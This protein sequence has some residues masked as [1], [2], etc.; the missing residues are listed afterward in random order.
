MAQ[1][2][3]D[4]RDVDF[5]LFEQ[6]DVETLS[7]HAQFAEFNRKT[8]EMVISEARNLAIKEILPTQQEGDEGCRFENGVVKPDCEFQRIRIVDE[9]FALVE[10]GKAVL[11]MKQGMVVTLRFVVSAGQALVDIFA[12]IGSAIDQAATPQRLKTA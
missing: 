2:I 1:R 9:V 3:A 11:D 5:V 12:V 7:E 10:Q 4:R 8:I 6:L